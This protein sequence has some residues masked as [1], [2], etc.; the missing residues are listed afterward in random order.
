M[1]E[2]ISTDSK[3]PKTLKPDY[4]RHIYEVWS[5]E[6]QPIAG[7]CVTEFSVGQCKRY[8]EYSYTFTG[9]QHEYIIVSHE[10]FSREACL[11][12]ATAVHEGKISRLSIDISGIA[13]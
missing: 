5:N 6:K 4:Q 10:S 13:K 9:R 12:F 11:S 1:G 7:R 8:Y 3:E 2:L